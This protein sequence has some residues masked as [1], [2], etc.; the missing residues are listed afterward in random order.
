MFHIMTTFGCLAITSL[1][2]PRQKAFSL[3]GKAF[4]LSLKGCPASRAIKI[5]G[6]L[7]VHSKILA[8]FIHFSPTYRVTGF[9]KHILTPLV[10]GRSPSLR[11][12][13]RSSYGTLHATTTALLL[14]FSAI[15]HGVLVKLRL[16]S[17]STEVEGLAHVLAARCS[18]IGIHIHSTHRVLYLLTHLTHPLSLIL[19][20]LSS[21]K[22]LITPYPY[23]V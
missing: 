10:E 17:L 22:I 15:L 20:F 8:A 9:S 11:E 2:Q 21:L 16:T 6:M 19:R 1:C 4:G 5:I 18:A 23:W 12:R 3:P 13:T 14:L 7:T